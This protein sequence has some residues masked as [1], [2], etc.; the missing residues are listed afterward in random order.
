MREIKTRNEHAYL[1][2][3]QVDLSSFESILKFKV[4]LEQWL[5]DSDL[6]SS[7]QLLVNNAGILAMSHRLTSKGHD[8]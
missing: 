3:F 5:L 4:S 2:A 8:E 1:K 6:H 7:V